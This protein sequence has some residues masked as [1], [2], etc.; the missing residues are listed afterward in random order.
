[1]NLQ[2]LRR[3]WLVIGFVLFGAFVLGASGAYS[4]YERIVYG[5]LPLG[6]AL[7]AFGAAAVAYGLDVRGRDHFDW[8]GIHYVGRQ[9]P[10]F[11]WAWIAFGVCYWVLGAGVIVIWFFPSLAGAAKP[12]W[13]R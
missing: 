8:R 10:F 12:G 9:V 7:I 5:A 1:M 2:R 13:M 11:G 4:R 6:L 3:R